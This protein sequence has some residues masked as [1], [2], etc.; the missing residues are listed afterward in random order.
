[1]VGLPS[2]DVEVPFSSRC[3]LFVSEIALP[4]VVVVMV[5]AVVVACACACECAYGLALI[6]CV[7]FHLGLVLFCVFFCCVV[8]S[9]AHRHLRKMYYHVLRFAVPRHSVSRVCH[10]RCVVS[11]LL[12]IFCQVDLY[13]CDHGLSFLVG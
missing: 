8:S 10:R 2:A 13:P 11:V 7:A 12:S 9:C 5:V 3:Y 6:L 1:M 4:I